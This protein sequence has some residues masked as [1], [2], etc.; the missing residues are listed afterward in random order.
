MD[1]DEV[2]VAEA[3]YQE[4]P[5]GGP[6]IVRLLRWSGG[7]IDIVRAA[8]VSYMAAWRAGQDENSDT[9]LIHS[10]MRRNHTSP[11]EHVAVTFEIVAPIFVLRQWHR[12]RTQS[13][14][15]ASARYKELDIGYYVPTIENI[16]VQSKTD[17]QGTERAEGTGLNPAAAQ[18]I[19]R[20]HMAVCEK[21]YR[22]LLEMGVSREQARIVL[23]VAAYSHMFVSM[24]LLNLF[25]FT[26]LRCDPHAQ[27][28][29]RVYAELMLDLVGRHVAPVAVAAYRKTHPE[30]FGAD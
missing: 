21:S 19:M 2:K 3:T 8:R 4:S 22:Q 26:T 13:Y 23:P 28:E 5:F 12:H 10:L 24:N 29:I 18:S 15:E 7:D 25:R 30:I 6:S 27:M 11:F 17:K 9:K 14:S 20:D 1:Q 16:G